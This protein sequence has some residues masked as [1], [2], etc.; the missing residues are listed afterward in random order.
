[1]DDWGSPW[2]DDTNDADDKI[3]D[4]SQTHIAFTNIS[5]DKSDDGH[6]FQSATSNT[7]KDIPKSTLLQHDPWAGL[8]GSSAWADT[9][10]I[11]EDHEFSDWTNNRTTGVGDKAI[12]A[13]SKE[14]WTGVNTQGLSPAMWGAGS[15]WGNASSDDVT[16]PQ[17]EPE[18]LSLSQTPGSHD[19]STHAMEDAIT[20]E[21]VEISRPTCLQLEIESLEV[22]AVTDVEP[23]GLTDGGVD[24]ADVGSETKP[25]NYTKP[26][27]REDEPT[28]GELPLE[29]LDS[30]RS[31][32][33]DPNTNAKGTL[34]SSHDLT[35]DESSIQNGDK[36]RLDASDDD[37]DFGDFAEEADF[38]DFVDQTPP[39]PPA[40]PDPRTS[41]IISAAVP[42]FDVDT[43]LVRKLYPIP[44]T[45]PNLP[46]LEEEIINTV[47]AR[48]AWYRLTQGG[49]LRK[50]NAA[51]DDA[52]VRVTWVGSK[53]QG[54][55]H[56]I[57]AKWASETRSSGI[58]G[59]GSQGLGAMFGWGAAS[60]T[61]SGP[62]MKRLSLGTEKSNPTP[63]QSHSRHVSETGPRTS[64][65]IAAA[66]SSTNS[67]SDPSSPRTPTFGWASLSNQASP[68]RT[69][70]SK[71]ASPELEKIGVNTTVLHSTHSPVHT[72]RRLSL[73]QKSVQSSPAASSPMSSSTS[74][75]SSGNKSPIFARNSLRSF[76]ELSKET[77]PPQQSSTDFDWDAFENM[78][79]PPV[80][81]PNPNIAQSSDEWGAFEKLVSAGSAGLTSVEEPVKT[82]G[83]I[84]NQADDGWEAFESL[85]PIQSSPRA[86]LQQSPQSNHSSV[87]GSKPD[88][89]SKPLDASKASFRSPAAE[90]FAS[91]TRPSKPAALSI[92]SFNGPTQADPVDD[93]DEWGQ[94]QS[95]AKS[96]ATSAPVFNSIEHP[97]PTGINGNPAPDPFAGL[98]G[99]GAFSTTLGSRAGATTMSGQDVVKN[100]VLDFGNPVSAASP[101]QAVQSGIDNWDL[102]FFERPSPASNQHLSGQP[103][104]NDLWDTPV[105]LGPQRGKV[106]LEEDKTIKRIIDG[107]PDLSYMLA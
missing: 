77:K 87:K 68:S 26:E 96:P 72:P 51:D 58:G 105:V 31:E 27:I 66:I 10:T 43:S 34:S 83:T 61:R 85:T 7:L 30:L 103:V 76:A 97:M 88:G 50:T 93:E 3:K 48:K 17:L 89:T 90:V 65:S 74:T 98:N 86:T 67:L 19:A 104:T 22:D 21:D 47:G 71:Q 9:P 99:F 24:D 95:P 1:M 102:S 23:L 52:Y 6:D 73:A 94:M 28:V 42:A 8:G 11:D 45:A 37:D 100:D 14:L 35:S 81:N 13:Q 25:E 20:A 84:Q 91:P 69:I 63:L 29:E 75:K 39:A 78:R 18:P 40:P 56:K 46:P 57:V 38:D 33:I 59:K 55:I 53:V 16:I 79:K 82:S 64:T 70:S 12:T 36:E 54:E 62:G 44:T 4:V 60:E 107:L 32:T 92:S 41:P 106:D 49:T 80:S 101:N 5:D 2:A 15:D